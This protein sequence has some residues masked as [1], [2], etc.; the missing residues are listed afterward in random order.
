MRMLVALAMLIVL[1]SCSDE[2]KAAKDPFAYCAAV[3]TIDAPDG[4]YTGEKVPEGL[5]AS[6]RKVFGFANFMPADEIARG[7]SWRCMDGK[8]YACYVGANLPCAA[9][10]NADRTPAPA[11]V[12]YCQREAG[13][14]II[15]AVVTGRETIYV[16]RCRNGAPEIVREVASA[17]ARG[18]LSNIWR[19]IPPP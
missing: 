5:I 14:D 10:A 11:L 4:R 15:P 19:E 2:K 12:E 16:W 3:G 18:F 7:T 9:K 1:A 6:M 13:A 17:D 8:L